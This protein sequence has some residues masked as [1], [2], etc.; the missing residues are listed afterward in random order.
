MGISIEVKIQY[1]YDALWQKMDETTSLLI[2]N[3][4]MR[5]DDK[6]G[7]DAERALLESMIKRYEDLFKDILQTDDK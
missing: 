5:L 1:F 3:P 7:A 4:G 6:L 2:T